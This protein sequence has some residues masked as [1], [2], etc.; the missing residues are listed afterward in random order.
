MESAEEETP[1][2]RRQLFM[3]VSQN[4]LLPIRHDVISRWI[5]ENL[6]ES[7][8]W[9]ETPGG[10]AQFAQH[11]SARASYLTNPPRKECKVM[12]DFE[13]RPA[14]PGFYFLS[15]NVNIV[16]DKPITIGDCVNRALESKRM[17]ILWTKRQP[18]CTDVTDDIT[19]AEK[20]LEL[21]KQHDCRVLLRAVYI[22]IT[23]DQTIVR[24]VALTDAEYLRYKPKGDEPI[25][26]DSSDDDS[27]DNNSSDNDSADDDSSGDE[28]AKGERT[29]GLPR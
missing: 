3:P 5:E 7:F 19:V 18:T 9:L 26:D 24:P 23:L 4:P 15:C 16:S 22:A 21:E 20:I 17:W 8:H 12:L 11:G 14:R 2:F 27:S 10:L 25:D 1:Y 6:V 28:L 13:A 29:Q